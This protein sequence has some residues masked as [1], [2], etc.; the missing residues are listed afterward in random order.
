M[1]ASLCPEP[2][3]KL[4]GEPHRGN[5]FL[6]ACPWQV[7]AHVSQ[8]GRLG[9]DG[10]CLGS[11]SA[12]SVD[13]IGYNG[14]MNLYAYCGDNPINA[15]DPMGTEDTIQAWNPPWYKRAWMAISPYIFP[16]GRQH[17]VEDAVMAVH[18]GVV[19]SV[20]FVQ[21]VEHELANLQLQAEYQSLRSMPIDQAHVRS[22]RF[23]PAE[24]P[25]SPMNPNLVT[26]RGPE[27]MAAG[28]AVYTLADGTFLVVKSGYAAIRSVLTASRSVEAM[29]SGGLQNFTVYADQAAE[30]RANATLSRGLN[31]NSQV[32]AAMTVKEVELAKLSPPSTRPFA[33]PAKLERM[34][35]FDWNKY[36][37]I[38]VQDEGGRLTILNG[39]TRV[40]A[41]QRA[42][43]KK[44]PAYIFK[45]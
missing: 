5:S 42:G 4:S 15:T 14:G 40:E 12:F 21:S 24:S 45:D 7:E 6:D 31:S 28:L 37:P 9:W 23:R 16:T 18:S 43:I 22:L 27:D 19:S 32:R 26:D 38:W 1:N 13:P 39:M 41:A 36:E 35:P 20:E 25:F 3:A 2:T 34:G 44:L 29:S 30:I 33:D 10:A 11:V 17:P 8:G